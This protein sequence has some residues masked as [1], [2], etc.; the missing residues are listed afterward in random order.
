MRGMY[1][2]N[3]DGDDWM[4][5][6]EELVEQLEQHYLAGRFQVPVP[7]PNKQFYVTIRGLNDIRRYPMGCREDDSQAYLV[8]H[9]GFQVVTSSPRTH[10]REKLGSSFKKTL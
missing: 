4:P 10:S 8:V 7:M 2:L 5:L 1:F 9:R 3:P 6:P